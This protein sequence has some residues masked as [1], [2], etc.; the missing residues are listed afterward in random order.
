MLITRFVADGRDPTQ[1][2]LPSDPICFPGH[3]Q[4]Q[5]QTDGSPR[6]K[7]AG[8]DNVALRYQENG[9]VTLPQNQPGKPANRGTIFVYGT[10]QSSPDDKFLDIFGKWNADGS[11]GNK[12][13]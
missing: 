2:I 3:Q 13:G 5:V 10:T 1:G 12:K 9:H 4:S 6:L 7:A 8:G 11:G